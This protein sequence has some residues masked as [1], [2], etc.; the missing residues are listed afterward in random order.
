V[1]SARSAQG[2]SE[3]LAGKSASRCGRGRFR[4]T[5]FLLL[6][7][8]PLESVPLDPVLIES[9]PLEPV[10]LEPA[11]L[12]PDA[13]WTSLQPTPAE[14]TR[15]GTDVETQRYLPDSAYDENTEALD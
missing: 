1:G 12:E 2:T 11:R 10:R 3:A 4:S 15:I 13:F 9:V 7:L 14:R 6:E 8:V 5:E